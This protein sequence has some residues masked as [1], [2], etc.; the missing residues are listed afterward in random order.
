MQCG[1]RND[2]RI[3]N[4]RGIP[5]IAAVSPEP[6][7]SRRFPNSGLQVGARPQGLTT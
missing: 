1:A 3:L 6:P 5:T 7:T 4:P 2:I